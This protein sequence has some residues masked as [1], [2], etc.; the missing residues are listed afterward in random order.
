MNMEF[1]LILT[2]V[3][4]I[5]GI[6]AAI[7]FWRKAM[8]Y[9]WQAQRL[10]DELERITDDMEA[11]KMKEE[12]L[13]NAEKRASA[14]E[15]Q[16]KD[17]Q[18]REH[19]REQ[20]AKAMQA[21]FENLANKIFDSKQQQFRDQSQKG[22][23]DILTPLKER[24]SEFQ[25]KV[26]ET[27]GQ[28]AKEQHHLK[29]EI[30]RIIEVNQ[31]MKLQT[32][33]LTKALKGDVKMQGNWGEIILEKVLESSGLRKGEHY[34]LQGEGMGL[35]HVDTGGHLRPDVVVHLPENK[36]LIIDSKVSLT[37][38]ERYVGEEEDAA[39][40][41]HLK[42]FVQSI[43]N[44][45]SG[46]ESKR[47]QDS[48]G[49]DT[50]DFVLMF[51]PIESAYALAL[52]TD[53]DLHSFAWDKRIYFVSP[54]TLFPI[55]H[56]VSSIW[57]MDMQNKNAQEIAKKGGDLYD[58]VAGFVED[59]DKLG[60]QIK[61]VNGTYDKAMNKLSEGR[62]NILRQTEQLRLMGAKTSKQLPQALLEDGED[63][64]AIEKKESA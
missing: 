46:L 33:S 7:H 43:R 54:S 63:T 37:H 45:V 55:L 23:Q 56:T 52:Q 39:K 35:K 25:K 21:Q 48:E 20:D 40:A 22:L 44:H 42:Q 16:V 6:V 15:Q 2:S 10:S 53:K 50:P 59:M 4:A 34:T 1:A 17:Q 26:D 60:N 49:L 29:Q 31:A 64:D 61:T 47:Y 62:G 13:L 41:L 36:H 28:H 11:Y 19:Q 18:A 5:A 8:R 12:A 51:M 14:L 30:A 38:Y 27:Y 9:A 58:K 32:E 3:S 24:F 57:R